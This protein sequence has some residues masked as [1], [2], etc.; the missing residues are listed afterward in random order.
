M[1]FYA[2]ILIINIDVMNI[3]CYRFDK[4]DAIGWFWSSCKWYLTFFKSTK[5]PKRKGV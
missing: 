2:T 3:D 4:E 5:D 1:D